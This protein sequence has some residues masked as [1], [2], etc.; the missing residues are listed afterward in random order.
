MV[1]QAATAHHRPIDVMISTMSFLNA[2][3]TLEVIDDMVDIASQ[4]GMYI[5][6]DY[7]PVGGYDEADAISSVVAGRS[8]LQGSHARDL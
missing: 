6:I 5:I 4:L 2:R 7:H 3:T 8:A 1:D